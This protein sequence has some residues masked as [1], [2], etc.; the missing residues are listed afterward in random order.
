MWRLRRAGPSRPRRATQARPPRQELRPGVRARP[1]GRGRGNAEAA[2]VRPPGDAQRVCVCVFVGHPAPEHLLQ[3]VPG[4]VLLLPAGAVAAVL[5]SSCCP[6]AC[7]TRVR[8]PKH[9]PHAAGTPRA[10]SSPPLK[11][12]RLIA[13]PPL[14]FHTFFFGPDLVR[15][16]K[17]NVF[18]KAP[19]GVLNLTER[20]LWHFI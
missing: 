19:R 13:A 5:R 11:P 17:G 10:V 12:G 16:S 7:A 1:R 8:T 18:F 20:C 4:L 14:P 9:P 15:G 3:S 6:A 2:W